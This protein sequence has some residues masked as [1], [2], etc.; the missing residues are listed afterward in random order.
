[1]SKEIQISWC[2]D[3]Y[4]VCICIL[5]YV[6]YIIYISNIMSIYIPSIPLLSLYMPIKLSPLYLHRLYRPH[7]PPI[8]N[9]YCI[10]QYQLTLSP[11]DH[12]SKIVQKK[13]AIKYHLCV[14]C[15]CIYIM[16]NQ[17]SL[18]ILILYTYIYTYI[19]YI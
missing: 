1:M 16:N 12:L 3:L 10:L 9:P 8:P 11:S 18:Y 5:E 14:S 4:S 19:I 6:L 2:S 7:I 15:T 13:K 17:S